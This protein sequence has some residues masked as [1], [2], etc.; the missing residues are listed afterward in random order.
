[1]CGDA[2]TPCSSKELAWTDEIDWSQSE[3]LRAVLDVLYFRTP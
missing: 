2:S 3:E 1:M